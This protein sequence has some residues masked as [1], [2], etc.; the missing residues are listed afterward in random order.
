MGNVKMEARQIN[1]RGGETLM[2][3]EEAIKNSGSTYELPI[4]SADTLGGVKVGSNLS[5]DSETGALSGTAPYSLPTA[6]SNTLGGVK[7]GTDL[8]I[9]GSGVLSVMCSIPVL[10]TYEFSVNESN[11]FVI[12]KTHNGTETTTTYP[13]GLYS[14]YTVDDKFTVEYNGNWVIT[15]L[16]SS[17]EYDIGTTW[18]SGYGEQ[19]AISELDFVVGSRNGTAS[20]LF[21]ELFSKIGE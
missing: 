8:S 15:L 3:V 2:S 20:E 17:T 12:V 13:S 19:P 6:A 5:I 14:T 4:A 11:G 21:T 1:Y 7:V 10:D 16:V 18:S 9:S